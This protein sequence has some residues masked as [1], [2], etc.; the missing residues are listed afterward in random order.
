MLS[1]ALFSVVCVLAVLSLTRRRVLLIGEFYFLYAVLTVMDE[2]DVPHLGPLTVYRALYI[3]LAISITARF[4]QDPDFLSQMR[5][6][7]LWS[8]SFVLALMIASALYSQTNHAFAPGDSWNVW[9]RLV[10]LLLFWFAACHIHQESDLMSVAIVVAGTSLVLSFW[11]IWSAARMDFEGYRGGISI[12][13]NYVSLFVFPG[14]LAL[15]SLL[16]ALKRF[17][18]KLICAVLLGCLLF[19]ALILASRGMFVAF[20]CGAL[21]LLVTAVKR[22]GRLLVGILLGGTVVFA[23]ALLLPGSGTL[24]ERFR[25]SDINTLDLRTLIWLHSLRHFADSGLFRMIFGQGLSSDRVIAGPLIHY[26]PNYHN[27]YLKWLMDKGVIGLGAFL[28]FL[29]QVGQRVLRS[30]HQLKTLMVGWLVFLLIAELTA[31]IGEMQMFWILFGVI[32]ASCP[33]SGGSNGL[34]K[35]V[36][37]SQ[38]LGPSPIESA[39]PSVV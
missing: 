35:L 15:I 11:V 12:D 33:L 26:L 36:P 6:W 22:K 5:R 37:R 25:E 27:D 14:A 18:L 39:S 1:V 19:A 17:L 16:F 10:T 32:A 31:V 29:Y 8:Y 2:G 20:V 24:L 34:Q 21:A 38:A 13:Q 9:F 30:S 3:I 7:P 23:I 4:M 28:F